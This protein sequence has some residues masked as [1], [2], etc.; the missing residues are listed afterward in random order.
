LSQKK[1]SAIIKNGGALF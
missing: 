1:I